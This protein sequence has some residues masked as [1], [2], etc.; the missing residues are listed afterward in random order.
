MPIVHTALDDIDA[1]DD[2]ETKAC[3][4]VPIFYRGR[5]YLVLL[6]VEHS[7]HY[8]EIMSPFVKAG[9]ELPKTQYPAPK[10]PT[11]PPEFF[12]VRRDD[13]DPPHPHP[14]GPGGSD[15]PTL[16]DDEFPTHLPDGREIPDKFWECSKTAPYAERMSAKK[17]REAIRDWLTAQGE[18]LPHARMPRAIAHRWA[19]EH[20]DQV[21]MP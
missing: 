8:D 3:E 12:H 20:P 11:M 19:V 4:E 15:S 1:L 13:I 2:V 6:S 9:K 16:F 17:I 21:P 18:Q 14:A 5:W 10:L 7:K